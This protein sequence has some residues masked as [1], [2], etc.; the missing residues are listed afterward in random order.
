MGFTFTKAR[1]A[2]SVPTFLRYFVGRLS[3]LSCELR[4]GVRASLH[5]R[6]DNGDETMQYMLLI[7]ES[8]DAYSGPDGAEVMEATLAG[9]MALIEKLT[10][11]GQEWSGNRLKPAQTATTIR[12]KAGEAALHD[13]PFAET[14]EELGGYYIVEAETLDQAIEWARMIPVPGDGAVEIRPIFADEDMDG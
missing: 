12:Y 4:L 14:H 13:G 5:Q 3:N 9:H 11:S 1:R 6:A 8:E 10:A 2:G 7:N